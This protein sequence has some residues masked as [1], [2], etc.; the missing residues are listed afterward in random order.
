MWPRTLKKQGAGTKITSPG[1]AQGNRLSRITTAHTVSD[2]P[3]APIFYLVEGVSFWK[4]LSILSLP[5]AAQGR[6]SCSFRQSGFATNKHRADLLQI[7]P[8]LILHP[9]DMWGLGVMRRWRQHQNNKREVIKQTICPGTAPL[10]HWKARHRNY[11]HRDVWNHQNLTKQA[12]KKCQKPFDWHLEKVEKKKICH[13]LLGVNHGS[14]WE[15]PGSSCHCLFQ[16][17]SWIFPTGSRSCLQTVSQQRPGQD[18]LFMLLA[19]AG[20]WESSIP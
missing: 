18:S 2:A 16:E 13:W 15:R 6:L 4:P 19:C 8:L 10:L 20:L 12:P 14:Q 3:L 7:S 17:N 5:G 11:D 9:V 1:C